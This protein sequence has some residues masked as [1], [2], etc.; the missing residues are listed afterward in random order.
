MKH[1]NIDFHIVD[2]LAAARPTVPSEKEGQTGLDFAEYVATIDKVGG[3]FDLVVIDG[4]AREA[5][6]TAAG[7]HLERGG[8]IVFDNSW[9]RRYRQVINASGMF[10]RRLRGITPTLP[11]PD[12]TS[13]LSLPR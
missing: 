12:Q 8:M 9:R 13:L 10:E 3:S 7:P 4:R 5:C 1:D 6:L 2:P 11:Y